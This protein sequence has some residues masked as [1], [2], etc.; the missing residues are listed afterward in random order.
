MKRAIII[1]GWGGNS[2]GGWIPWVKRE[3]E[4]K[5]VK[6]DT[7]NM[8]NS[9]SPVIDHWVPH[10]QKVIGTPDEDTYLVGHSI[11]CQ[12][13]LRY[14][15]KN[16]IK[17]GGVCFVAGWFSL[18]GE[19][20]ANPED[21]VIAKPWVETPINLEK[22]RAKAP[23]FISIFSDDDPF[24][25]EENWKQFETLGKTIILHEKG[26]VEGQEPEILKAVLEILG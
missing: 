14:L 5:G 26:H 19:V 15:E 9:E 1:H 13:I 24:V 18:S 12:T 17:V 25:P 11:G 3:L 23:K 20:I 7:P 4:A 22:V 21:A 16:N 2:L 10:L 6:V 8:P